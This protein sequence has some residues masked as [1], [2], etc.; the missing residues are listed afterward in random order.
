[1]ECES[2]FKIPNFCLSNTD[3]TSSSTSQHTSKSSVYSVSA[4]VPVTPNKMAPRLFKKHNGKPNTRFV[5]ITGKHAKLARDFFVTVVDIRWRF[6]I[7][8]YLSCKLTFFTFKN[9]LKT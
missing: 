4:S 9:F 1:M 3:E 2:A 6:M 7:L 5:N 8:I